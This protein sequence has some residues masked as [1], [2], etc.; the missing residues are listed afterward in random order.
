MIICAK[1]EGAQQKKKRGIFF[2][3]AEEDASFTFELPCK[4]DSKVVDDNSGVV[5]SPCLAYTPVCHMCELCS[6]KQHDGADL[7]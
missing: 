6:C 4:F 7:L 2:W 5:P 3:K 1:K